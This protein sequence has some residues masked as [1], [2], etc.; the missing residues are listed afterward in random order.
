MS[1]NTGGR[2]MFGSATTETG[3]S[4]VSQYLTVLDTNI[5]P[6]TVV[7]NVED[8]EVI[9]G[10]LSNMLGQLTYDKENHKI[11]INKSYFSKFDPFG[12]G[13]YEDLDTIISIL[14]TIISIFDIVKIVMEQKGFKGTGLNVSV[15]VA[16]KQVNFLM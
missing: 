10:Y 4:I 9:I 14:S 15:N 16:P 5:K 11:Y 12:L 3:T 8:L 13:A 6:H 7:Q 2:T 1:R